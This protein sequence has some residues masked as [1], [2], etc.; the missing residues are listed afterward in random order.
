MGEL[1][2]MVHTLGMSRASL[3][4]AEAK[5]GNGRAEPAGY[6]KNSNLQHC[7]S[8]ADPDWRWKE[9][10]PR[11]IRSCASSAV[12]SAA[13]GNRRHGNANCR[14]P[15]PGRNVTVAGDAGSDKPTA[16]TIHQSGIILCCWR[17]KYCGDLNVFYWLLMVKWGSHSIQRL[18]M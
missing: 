16:S 9:L 12:I 4:I 11:A 3:P 10:E 18:L 6:G 8:A 14:R 15:L 7:S 17:S 13:G 5:P 1:I 2:F